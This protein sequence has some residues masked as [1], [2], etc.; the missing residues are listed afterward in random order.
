LV[1]HQLAACPHTSCRLATFCIPYR[2]LFF[3]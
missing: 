3:K 1:S 2:T